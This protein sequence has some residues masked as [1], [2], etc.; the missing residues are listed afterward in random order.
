MSNEI[1]ITDKSNIVAIADAVR[2]KT[3]STVPMNLGG[4][5]NGI[6]GIQV[7]SGSF[8][9]APPVEEKD[10]NFYDY[11][12]TLLYSYT[13]EE[14]HALT[15]L[16]QLPSHDGLVCQGWNWTLAQ[17]KAIPKA[18]NVGAAYITDDGKTR[19]YLEWGQDKYRTLTI[20]F[21]QTVANGVTIDWGDGSPTETVSGTGAVTATHNFVQSN[22][23]MTLLPTGSCKMTLGR[24]SSELNLFDEKS[25]K[26]MVVS[27]V[28]KKVE[29][30]Q[31]VTALN[32]HCF[33]YCHSL[34]TLT[35]PLGV[36]MGA[37]CI[38]ESSVKCMIN[39]DTSGW[40]LPQQMA[41]GSSVEVVSLPPNIITIGIYAF[42]NA[43]KLENANFVANLEG[44]NN[45]GLS[46]TQSLKTVK[47]HDSVTTIPSE[48]IAY[49]S[50]ITQMTLPPNLTTITANAFI[51]DNNI[52]QLEIP[53]SVTSI[54]ASA[55]A[56]MY[57][58]GYLKF[59][60]T[61]PPTVA[62]ANA[63]TG[64]PTTC[65]VEVPKGTLATYQAATNY[66]GIAAQMVEV[67]E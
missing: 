15:E 3:G 44:I 13:I 31:D 33:F 41:Q 14:A 24:T 61:T 4:I 36:T 21:T 60:P 48:F 26:S 9:P 38:R 1:I 43:R 18:A 47:F 19:L 54:G 37:G 45:A 11:D 17:V 5:V 62:N 16:P 35:I 67:D 58:L 57:A 65:V 46:G 34:E 22:C 23:V 2:S 30:G 7:G 25:G 50:R 20:H 29:V 56:Q 52:A 55:F 40:M 42:Y 6:N 66:S 63:F 10:V 51:A 32:Q 12:G 8:S 28:L 27:S 59:L 64:I 39:T 53:T 49:S